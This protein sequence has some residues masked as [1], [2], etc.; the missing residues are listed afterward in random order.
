MSASSFRQHFK[1]LTGTSPLQYLKNLRL[2]E[3]RDQMLLNGLD[4]SQ[5]SGFVGYVE[6]F[7]V[8]SRIQSIV[9]AASSERYSTFTSEV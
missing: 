9:W 2:Q 8:Q 3:A 7:A 6:C 5:A 1:A 4:A